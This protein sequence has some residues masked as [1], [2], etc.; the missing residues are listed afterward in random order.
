ML[1]SLPATLAMISRPSTAAPILAVF[2]IV[3]VPLVLY[4]AG[5][6]WLGEYH[7]WTDTV[8]GHVRIYSTPWQAN[9]FGPATKVESLLRQERVRTGHYETYYPSGRLP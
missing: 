1:G 9:L 4:V 6:F 8:D 7:D 3:A 5:Y 2:A